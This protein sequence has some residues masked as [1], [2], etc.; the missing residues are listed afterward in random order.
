MIGATDGTRHHTNNGVI[1]GANRV[2][3]V[4]M[5]TENATSPLHRND[6]ILLDTSPFT[7]P[8][9]SGTRKTKTA[10][11]IT[12][13]DECE[14]IHALASFTISFII[15]EKTIAKLLKRWEVSTDLT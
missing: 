10:A 2:E 14:A 8:N 6:M 11:A 7:H 3:A 4:V 13:V 1:T 5:P 12:Y 15:V 9:I